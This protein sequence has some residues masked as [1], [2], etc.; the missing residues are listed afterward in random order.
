MKKIAIIQSNY[1]P[2]KGYF[3]IINMVDV[4][5]LLDDV[6][7]TI[8]DWRNRNKIKVPFGDR[9]KWLTIPIEGKDKHKKLI[10]EVKVADSKWRKIHWNTIK[11]FYSKTPY[12]KEYKDIF[13]ELYL[14]SHEEFLSEVNY[15]FIKAINHILGIDTEIRWSYEFDI[16]QGKNERLI[17]ICKQL[18][19]DVYLTGPVA[20]SYLDEN[21]FAQEGI[22]VEW[23]D[24]SNYPEYPQLYPPFVHAV[25]IIDLIFNTGKNAVHYMK[26]FKDRNLGNELQFLTTAHTIKVGI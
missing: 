17:S 18:N 1:I 15:K 13:E 6:Q 24:Y 16:V 4:F 10:K 19:A 23:M 8:R 9:T 5:V 7:Y 26:S 2:W 3:D 21:L 25:S 22:K 12:F 14:N 20:K 11:Q